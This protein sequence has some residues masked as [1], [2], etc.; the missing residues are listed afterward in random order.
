MPIRQFVKGADGWH[1]RQVGLRDGKRVFG[2][3]ADAHPRGLACP[4]EVRGAAPGEIYEVSLASAD[5][6]QQLGTRIR[7]QRGAL[8]AIDYGYGDLQTGET[9]QAVRNHAYVD[10]LEA[11]GEV[12][13]SAH[14]GFGA[15]RM[16]AEE[17]GLTVEK[18]STQRDFLRRLSASSSAPHALARGQ[19]GHAWTKSVRP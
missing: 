10:P 7:N 1:E 3:S 13:L 12:D 17:L 9:L 6:M 4:R 14:V 11:P 19:S 2:L 8:L 16:V 18:L 5:I 15:V